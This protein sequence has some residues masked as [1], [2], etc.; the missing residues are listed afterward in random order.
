MDTYSYISENGTVR[1]I[2]D[3][4]AKAK[5]EEQ[6]TEIQANRNAIN[7]LSASVEQKLKRKLTSAGGLDIAAAN[8]R[9]FLLKAGQYLAEMGTLENVGEAVLVGG[10]WSGNQYG[11]MLAQ[12]PDAIRYVIYFLGQFVIL[13][14]T[15]NIR[16]G[17]LETAYQVAATPL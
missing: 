7:A 12:K 11:M 9:E 10:A 1:Q 8:G 17:S 13:Q 16:S 6:D 5:N 15:Y 3:L 4:L 2:E 14:G